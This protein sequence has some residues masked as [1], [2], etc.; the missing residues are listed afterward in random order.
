MFILEKIKENSKY[1]TSIIAIFLIY[2]IIYSLFKYRILPSFSFNIGNISLP[3]FQTTQMLFVF[4]LMLFVSYFL[5]IRKG[6]IIWD[7][8]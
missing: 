7:I 8:R 6:N 5:F 4:P 2:F 3:P 1:I